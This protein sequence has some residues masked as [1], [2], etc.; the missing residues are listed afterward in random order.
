MPPAWRIAAAS[1]TL[2]RLCWRKVSLMLGR[3][4]YR[5]I[6]PDPDPFADLRAAADARGADEELPGGLADGAGEVRA[7][8]A[9]A[10]LG[11]I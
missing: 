11:A 1:S 2:A 5:I 9:V 3:S 4:L 7:A 8:R 10:E 6:D